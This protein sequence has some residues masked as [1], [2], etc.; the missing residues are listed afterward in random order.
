MKPTF[1]NINDKMGYDPKN[2]DRIQK[3]SQQMKDM[4]EEWLPEP[5][6]FEIQ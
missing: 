6:E 3:A 5:S 1:F 4:L 2:I